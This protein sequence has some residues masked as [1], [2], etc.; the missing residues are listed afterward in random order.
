MGVEFFAVEFVARSV[1]SAGMLSG[2]FLAEGEVEEQLVGV[3]VNVGQQGGRAQVVGVVEIH[4]RR[5]A[6]G[7]GTGFGFGGGF[8]PNQVEAG[9]AG[10]VQS[11]LTLALAQRPRSGSQEAFRRL[12]A[13][14]GGEAG[15]G[16][17]DDRI[18]PYHFH[19]WRLVE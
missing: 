2:H 14:L 4:L 11:V 12:G 19:G 5:R 7:V 16:A 13:Y 6:L 15:G 17:T 8:G 10:I 9:L 3:S 1:S 18:F